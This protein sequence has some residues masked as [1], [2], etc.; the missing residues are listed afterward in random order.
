MVL[1]E[2]GSEVGAGVGGNGRAIDVLFINGLALS[3]SA[4]GLL[5][6]GTTD[7]VTMEVDVEGGS[8]GS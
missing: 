8:K 1:V 3:V 7:E 4:G 2:L 5:T 6:G